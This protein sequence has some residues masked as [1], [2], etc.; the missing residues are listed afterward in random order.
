MAEIHTAQHLVKV[1]HIKFE[2][3]TSNS[4]G[5]DTRSQTDR[6]TDRQTDITST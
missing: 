1:S 5:T 6:Q 2:E 4:L 3:N